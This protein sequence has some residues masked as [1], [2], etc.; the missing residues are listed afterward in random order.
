[1]KIKLAKLM[2]FVLAYTLNIIG[3]CKP[4][5]SFLARNVKVSFKLV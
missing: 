5:K 2:T 4:K 1:M 3:K